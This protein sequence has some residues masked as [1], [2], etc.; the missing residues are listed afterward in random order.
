M[1]TVRITANNNRIIRDYDD[2]TTIR[3][4]C[5][6]NGIE[7]ETYGTF[8]DGAYLRANEYDKTLRELGFT[9]VCYLA[10]IVMDGGA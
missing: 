3:T 6:E 5:E 8:L 1:V 7:Y 9:E 10:R 2:S 4:I